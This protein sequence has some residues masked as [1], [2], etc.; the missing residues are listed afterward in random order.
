[1]QK[2][3]YRSDNKKGMKKREKELL[4]QLLR[5]SKLSDREIAKKLGTSQST[6]TRSGHKLEKKIIQ[7]YT[8]VP[9]L[10]KLGI[11][12]IAF[13][14]GSCS[15]PTPESMKKIS[16][17]MEEQSN[18]IFAGHGEGMGKTGIVVTFHKDFSE[19]T[20]FMRKARLS[21]KGFGETLES[22]VLPTDNLIR[23]LS[24]GKAIENLIK[25]D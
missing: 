9:D 14:L 15:M 24:M 18:V 11:K 12:L 2:Y 20:E 17:F 19:Y 23:T 6:I 4:F 7:S 1:M 22:F 5:D 3:K 25:D 10:S 16:D 8:I 13:T 21:C